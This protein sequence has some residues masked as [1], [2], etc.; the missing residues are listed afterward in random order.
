MAPA[1]TELW[2]GITTANHQGVVDEVVA[3]G[4]AAAGPEKGGTGVATLVT[5]PLRYGDFLLLSTPCSRLYLQIEGV[6]SL[7]SLYLLCVLFFTIKHD[8]Q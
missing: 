7:V 6:I 4:E 1:G 8:F 2:T 5:S 3:A